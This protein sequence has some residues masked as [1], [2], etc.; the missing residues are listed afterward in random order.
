[1]SSD[2]GSHHKWNMTGKNLQGVK[3]PACSSVISL[4]IGYILKN[5]LTP[6]YQIEAS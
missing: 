1:M 6:L 4:P 5:K 2:V 3:A